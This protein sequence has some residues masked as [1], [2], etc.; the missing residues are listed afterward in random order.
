MSQQPL[1]TRPVNPGE[2]LLREKF[3]ESVAG[4]SD[5]MDRLARQVITVELAVPGLYATVLKLTQGNEA[6]VM[7]GF[8]FYATFLCWFLALAL[9]LIALIPR[10]WRVDPTKLKSDPAGNSTEMGLQE[11]FH[12]SAQYKRR[13]LIPSILLF[14]IGIL[15]AAVVVL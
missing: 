13:L 5:L 10:N 3:A 7:A 15:S 6:T 11:F 9:A 2:K 1:S 4:Q 12:K 14:W 8:W